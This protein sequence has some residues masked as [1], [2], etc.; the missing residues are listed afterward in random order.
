MNVNPVRNSRAQSTPEKK[1]I[2]N[3]IKFHIM[4]VLLIC[5]VQ[6]SAVAQKR[7][8]EVLIYRGASDASAAVAINENMFIVADDENNV[9]RVYGTDR[10]GMP[11]FSYDL[12]DFLGIESEHPEADIEGATRVAERI[13]WITSHGRNKD[14]QLRPNRY[15]FFATTVKAEDGNIIIRPVGLACKDLVHSLLKAK[16]MQ[17]LGL[18]KAT[19]F[20]ARKLSKKERQK[21][22][23][24]EQGLNIEGL[25]A[26]ADG[27]TLYIG[28]RNPRPP[29]I[30]NLKFSLKALVVP[31]KNPDAVIESSAAPIFDEPMLWDL[32][33]LGIRSMEYSHFHKAYFIIAGSHDESSKSVLYRWSGRADEPPK[34]V[35]DLHML[36]KDFTPE[37]LVVFEKSNRLLMLSDDGS[38]PIKV[39][40]DSECMDGQLN[41]DG[42]CPNKFLA[43]PDKKSFRAIWFTP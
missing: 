21:L 26:S 7:A 1:E 23:P 22:A 17:H 25:C 38:L 43:D 16:T 2:Y 24:K 41:K 19:Q 36:Q 32:G 35:R 8:E 34:F 29:L 33:G 27:T 39:T 3:G 9:L 4:F 40:D 13:Y 12:T 30:K 6:Y 15:R 20:N 31:L 11:L 42:T 37:A 10:P 18:D 14:G 28:F 5:G